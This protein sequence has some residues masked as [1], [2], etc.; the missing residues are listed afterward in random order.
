MYSFDSRR[1]CDP[2]SDNFAQA[3]HAALKQH[4]REGHDS[5]REGHVSYCHVSSTSNHDYRSSIVP[6]YWKN[7]GAQV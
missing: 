6:M 4:L 3:E 7:D 1:K 5:Y 2:Y